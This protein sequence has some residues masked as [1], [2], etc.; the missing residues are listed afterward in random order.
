M[1]AEW[2]NFERKHGDLDDYTYARDKVC[3]KYS[4]H[5][6]FYHV[7]NFLTEFNPLVGKGRGVFSSLAGSNISC[8]LSFSSTA[9]QF[10]LFYKLEDLTWLNAQ[11]I[12]LI[13]PWH[14]SF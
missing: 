6:A 3:F 11:L 8:V 2:I 5:F 1:H 10:S 7:I 14:T 4:F 13:V 12:S 9:H